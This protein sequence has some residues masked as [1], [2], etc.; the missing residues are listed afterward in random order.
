MAKKN[1]TQNKKPSFL[2]RVKFIAANPTL[3]FMLGLLMGAVAIF[4]C[5]SFLSFFS[6]GGADQSTID[7]AAAAVADADASV[8]NTSGRGGAIVAD[9]LV[10]GCFGWSSVLLIPLFVGAMLRLMDI[11]RPNLLKWF[12]MAVFGIVWGSVFFAFA[13]GS[14]FEGS[15]MSPGGRHGETVAAWLQAQIG[16]VGAVLVLALTLI[17]FMTYVTRDTI[18]W[19]QKFFSFS[20]IPKPNASVAGEDDGDEE[21]DTMVEEEPAP[22]VIEFAGEDA[23]D[24]SPEYPAEGDDFSVDVAADE[25]VVD[26]ETVEPAEE[27]ANEDDAAAA[28]DK[29][30]AK[31][32]AEAGGNELTMEVQSAEGDDDM[33]GKMLRPINP[34]DELS[35]YKPPTIDL[36]DKYEQAAQSI[37]MNEQQANKNKIVE[38]L[39]NFDIEISSIKATVGP[40]ITL[41]EITPAP[42]VRIGKIKNLEDDIAMSLAALCIRIIAPIP[43]KGTVGIEVPNAHKQIVPMASLLNSRKYKETD[44][45]LPLALGKTISNEVFMVDMA[46]MPHL[47]VAGA[48]GMGKSVGLNAIITSLLYKMHPAYLKFVMVDPKM[49][50]LSLYNVLEKHFL[51]KLEGEDE[52]IITDVNKVVRTLKSLCVEMDSRYRLLQMAMVRSV[53]EYNEKFLNKELLPT[54]GHRFMPYIVVI[55]DEYGDLMMTAGREVEQPIARIAQKARAVGIHMIIATQRPTTNIITG[56]IKANFPARMAFRVISVIDSRTILDRQG[57]N[58]LQG[59][60]DML[61]LAGNDPVRVQCALVETKEVERVCAHIAKQQGYPTAYILP[62]PDEVPADGGGGS[63]GELSSDKLD[64]LFADAA[65]IVVIHQ[66]GST[67]L[68][69]RK[70]NVGF[71]RAGRIMDQLCQTGLVGEQEGSK[72]RQVLCADE[73]DL[74]FRL[75]Q[76]MH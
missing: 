40:T 66:Q 65:R 39:R 7:A 23:A 10:N 16:V 74:E 48:T 26:D 15:F 73:A 17:A 75:K 31:I 56:T 24:K 72:P 6:S 14:L 53:K 25:D 42:G 70:L 41:Y 12:F 32:A 38:V 30:S 49:V 33:G 8:Q 45:A 20:F 37:D 59:R 68:I 60:G 61:F 22:K 34:K 27:L 4:L 9:Y 1:N 19:L 47:L 35:Y 29:M 63:R 57:A 58:Q 67:S 43:G 18:T 13:L 76:L 46:K 54:K 36:L 62:E 28:F 5:S 69:Q 50:E 44:M 21:D 55:I 3:R 71:N 64:P 51:A 2:Q 52:P 11:Y